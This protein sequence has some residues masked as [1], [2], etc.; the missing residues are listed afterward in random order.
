MSHITITKIQQR[1][2][3]FVMVD[4][5]PLFDPRYSWAEKG[6]LATLLAL[7]DSGSVKLTE[8]HH[9]SSDGERATKTA[10]KGLKSLGHLKVINEGGRW[11]AVR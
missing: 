8:M 11:Y 3:P 4:K 2:R 9:F 1:E 7:K 6:I 5:D 10:Q